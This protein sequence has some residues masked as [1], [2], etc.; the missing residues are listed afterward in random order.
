MVYHSIT[1]ATDNLWYA[2]NNFWNDPCT[3]TL[4][5]MTST[6]VLAWMV[7]YDIARLTNELSRKIDDM[8]IIELRKA[9]LAAVAAI[10]Q[11]K[12]PSKV[13]RNWIKQ[14]QYYAKL[15]N[16]LRTKGA[17]AVTRELSMMIDNLRRKSA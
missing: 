5:F 7:T 17:N 10:T 11:S 4:D 9:I 15:L 12:I 3:D 14:L 13:A 2:K 16:M 1:R 8:Q 6:T